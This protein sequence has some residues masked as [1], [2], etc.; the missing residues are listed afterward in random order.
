MWKTRWGEANEKGTHWN[1]GWLLQK[2]VVGWKVD[3]ITNEI[4]TTLFI[5][6]I[7]SDTINLTLLW[8]LETFLVEQFICGSKIDLRW[9][10][11]LIQISFQQVFEACEQS[12][13]VFIHLWLSWWKN[14]F[15]LVRWGRF[16]AISSFKFTSWVT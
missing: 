2:N 3:R 5:V 14:S 9:S 8:H 12:A 16:S 11:Y 4:T 6:S 10:L 13:I 7:K 1:N 15:F